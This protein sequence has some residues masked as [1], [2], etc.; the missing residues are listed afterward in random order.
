MPQK[1]PG[2]LEGQVYTGAIAA[3]SPVPI[4]LADGFYKEP[5]GLLELLDICPSGWQRLVEPVIHSLAD[6]WLWTVLILSHL[7]SCTLNH[8]SRGLS[9]S[10]ATV[11]SLSFLTVTRVAFSRRSVVFLHLSL[12]TY[13]ASAVRC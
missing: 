3:R 8:H 11:K 13:T 5:G 4:I 7:L 10:S 1:R 6:W 2:N 9:D 12:F